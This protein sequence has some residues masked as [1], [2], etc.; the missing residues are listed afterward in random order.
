MLW[1]QT[2]ENVLKWSNNSKYLL[3]R[4]LY[5]DARVEWEKR[6]KKRSKS[7]SFRSSEWYLNVFFLLLFM[8]CLY[9]LYVEY[10]CMNQT[11]IIVVITKLPFSITE[12]T[13]L[14]IFFFILN[15]HSL[16]ASHKS[17]LTN[18]KYERE[19]N[20]YMHTKFLVPLN[21]C[22]LYACFFSV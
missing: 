6:G 15:F 21:F 2:S 9:I 7:P 10:L 13:A 8:Y 20:N 3:H 17:K 1:C 11:E 19:K 5:L 14:G 12:S 22:S 18:I 16:W 4:Q